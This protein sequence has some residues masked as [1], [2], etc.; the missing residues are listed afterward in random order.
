MIEKMYEILTSLSEEAQLVAVKKCEEFQLDMDRG[1]TPLDESFINLNSSRTTLIDAI[2]KNKLI[3]LPITIQK[4]LLSNLEAVSASFEEL[5][6][7]TDTLINLTDKIE[8]LHVAIWKYDLNNLSDEVLGFEKKM[9]Q[10]KQLEL[11]SQELKKTLEEGLSVKDQLSQLTNE[12]QDNNENIQKLLDSSNEN[13]ESIAEYLTQA[14]QTD[15]Q[16]AAKLV[17][18]QQNET[19][20]N[21]HLATSKS[22]NIEINAIEDSIKKFHGSIDDYSNKMQETEIA[23]SNTVKENTEKTQNL[24]SELDDLEGQIKDQI[25]KATGHSLFHS[26]QTRKEAIIKSKKFWTK[27]IAAVLFITILWSVWLIFTT[28]NINNVFYLK[29]TIAAPLFYALGFC[30]LQYSHERRLEEEYAFKSNISI[31]L[32]PYQ[33]L[34]EKL[35]GDDPEEKKKYTA[36]IIDSISKVYTS[37]TDKVFDHKKQK[38]HNGFDKEGLKQLKPLIDFITSTAKAAK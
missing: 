25:Q 30:T 5:K 19:S 21:A 8:E 10:L 15:Q 26:F 37:P 23:S 16:I 24:I 6:N 12:A 38:K 35:V 27:A 13:I 20:I 31:S 3:Q 33:E 18:V 32:I 2:E 34:V 1:I 11:K 4:D 9:N 28:T 22:S 14:T 36:F 17:T 7:G 29:L